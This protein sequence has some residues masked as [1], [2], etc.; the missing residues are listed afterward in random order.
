MAK[1]ADLSC[2]RRLASSI[3]VKPIDASF[4]WHDKMITIALILLAYFIQTHLVISGDVAFLAMAADRLLA[5]GHYASDFFETNPPMNIYLYIPAC[6]IAK[7]FALS[8]TAALRIYIFAVALTSLSLCYYLL[9]LSCQLRLETSKVNC[10]PARRR[11]IQLP[12]IVPRGPV[13]VALQY[14]LVFVLFIVPANQFGQREHFLLMLSLPYLFSVVLRLERKTIPITLS[15]VIGLLA[16]VG[17]ALKPFFLITPALVELFLIWQKKSALTL[18]RVEALTIAAVILSSLAV[19]WLFHRDYLLIILPVVFHYY[20]PAKTHPWLSFFESPFVVYCLAAIVFYAMVYRFT[21][22]RYLSAVLFLALLGFI[23]AFTIPR[24]P[25]FY[26]VLP[27][28]GVAYLL[29]VLLFAD[30]VLAYLA[31]PVMVLLVGV[32][33]FFSPVLTTIEQTTYWLAD[34]KW[35][36]T[37]ALTAYFNRLPAGPLYCFSGRTTADCFPLVE[38]THRSFGSRQ[39]FFWWMNGMVKDVYYPSLHHQPIPQN[40]WRD[41]MVLSTLTADDLNHYQPAFIMVNA[42]EESVYGEDFHFIAFLSRNENFKRAWQPYRF[43]S[44]VGDI[45]IYKRG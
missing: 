44:R 20:F 29:T 5:G 7:Y 3:F 36:Q 2:Q 30:V 34:A 26:H 27:A 11:G 14:T 10:H 13:I 8:M 16:G 28:L 39:T 24:A 40:T 38:N 45:E 6:L 43:L 4:R 19:T 31:T 41:F 12:S 42:F 1:D 32:L 22:Y 33:M 15:I 18:F 21:R 35:G 25:W 37:A 17:F 23:A 9:S